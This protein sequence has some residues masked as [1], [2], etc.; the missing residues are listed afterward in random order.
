MR[1][2]RCNSRQGHKHCLESISKTTKESLSVPSVLPSWRACEAG[3]PVPAPCQL[4]TFP[5]VLANV[6]P[7]RGPRLELGPALAA[8]VRL[9]V[10]HLEDTEHQGQTA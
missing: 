7:Q 6:A 1:G 8:L 2:K 9:P 3:E 10:A 4:L 5:A